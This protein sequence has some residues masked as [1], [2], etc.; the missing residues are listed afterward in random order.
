MYSCHCEPRHGLEGHQEEQCGTGER[1][2][3]GRSMSRRQEVGGAYFVAILFHKHHMPIAMDTNFAKFEM[4][5]LG[6]ACLF[7][8][9][10]CAIVVRRMVAGFRRNSE[11]G[12]WR[13]ID[14]LPR[15]WI[16][17]LQHTRNGRVVTSQIRRL[18]NLLDQFCRVSYWRWIVH[19]YI[20]QAPFSRCCRPENRFLEGWARRF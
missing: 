2:G 20:R 13:N 15:C 10:H 1:R 8:E 17:C 5:N 16:H 14:Q 12:Q 4:C 9:V 11:N 3:D 18:I 19:R 6:T 7:E